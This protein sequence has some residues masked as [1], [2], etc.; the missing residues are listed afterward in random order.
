MKK[1]ILILMLIIVFSFSLNTAAFVIEIKDEVEVTAPEITLAEIAEINRGG[2]SDSQLSSLKKLSFDSSPNPGYQ[3]RLSRV[4]VELTV[5]NQGYNK[6]QFKLLMPNTVLVNRESNVVSEAEISDLV[7]SY[8]KSKLDFAEDKIIIESRSSQNRIQIA[9]GDYE[10]KV[11]EE[12]NLSLPNTSLKLEVWQN[13]QRQ[14]T[15]F[16][17]VKIELI[18]EAL[19]A[20]RNLSSNSSI[21]KSDFELKEI[22]V[23]GDPDQIISSWSEIDFNNVELSRSLNSGEA[24]TKNYLK[25]PYAVKWGQKLN[26]RV[27]VNNINI[28]TFVEAKERG[29][30]GEMI[31]VE[32]LDSGYRFQVKVVSPTEVKM[33]SD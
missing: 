11:A 23:S 18:L 29:K 7:E 4:L 10:L 8:L 20:S 1:N 28:S 5:Q 3:K 19:T 15:I 2:L 9:A 24:L 13:E 31:T 6:N 26:L 14:R 21:S 25:I 22:K 33:I 30:I 27:N 17:P 16:Y 32:N 12:Q